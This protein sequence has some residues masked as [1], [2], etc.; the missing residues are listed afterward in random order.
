VNVEQKLSP[1]VGQIELQPQ[2]IQ[3]VV[4]NLIVNALDAVAEAPEP[5]IT[6]RTERRA[7]NC[8]IEVIDNGHG[9]KP[10]H[11]ARLFEPF[12]TTK[13]VGQGTGLG[14]SISYS[15]VQKQGG[16]ITVKSQPG[17]GTAFTVRLPATNGTPGGASRE[18]ES[19]QK[20]PIS[21]ENPPAP[22]PSGEP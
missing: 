17:R 1:D 21:S 22:T 10:E 15:L 14:L 8:L 13:P 4:V 5:K 19:G 7:D 16:H 9:I 11:L 18:R 20:T 6:V 12:F 2:A 3:Q